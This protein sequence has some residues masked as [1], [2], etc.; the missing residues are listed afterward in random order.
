VCK[1][2]SLSAF[3]RHTH[4]SHSILNITILILTRF[5]DRIE[6][7]AND[8]FCLLFNG[9]PGVHPKTAWRWSCH[10]EVCQ[11]FCKIRNTCTRHNIIVTV[12][13]IRTIYARARFERS[14]FSRRPRKTH[15]GRL[16]ITPV[17]RTIAVIFFMA[18][19][20]A[21]L[22]CLPDVFRFI[23]RTRVRFRCTMLRGG[24]PLRN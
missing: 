24:G 16:L 7:I 17:P 14:R 13:T 2:Q 23:R 21:L 9:P 12:V 19:K 22:T 11:V 3:N 15:R 18:D 10:G 1:F 4:Q 5:V 6:S 20:I 8:Y